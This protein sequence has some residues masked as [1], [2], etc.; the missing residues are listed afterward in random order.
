V[1]GDNDPSCQDEQHV[2]EI[3]VTSLGEVYE[4]L[5]EHAIMRMEDNCLDIPEEARTD[6][7]SAM[8]GL[9]RVMHRTPT[10]KPRRVLW[11]RTLVARLLPL[12]TRL[13]IEAIQRECETGVDLTP[14]FSRKHFDVAFNDTLLNDLNVQ[15]LHLGATSEGERMVKSTSELL[16]VVIHKDAVYFLDLMYHGAFKQADFVTLLH[17]NWPTLLGEPLYGWFPT[18]EPLSSEDRARLRAAGVMCPVE[19]GGRMYLPPGGGVTTARTSSNVVSWAHAALDDVRDCHH[20]VVQNQTF[21]VEFIQQQTGAPVER[22]N[23]TARRWKGRWVLHNE[24]PEVLIL[25]GQ[26][27]VLPTS[28]C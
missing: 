12:E 16:F 14:R 26:G 21:I 3:E 27:I 8:L 17:E 7:F 20:W 23:L 6:V 11:S 22:L 15:H 19:V 1:V 5:R 9:Y 25:P 28:P 13:R 10:P 4:R 2:S 24:T 18:D